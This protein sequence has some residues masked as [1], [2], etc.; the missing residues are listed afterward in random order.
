MVY[1]LLAG[2]E[3]KEWLPKEKPFVIMK[4]MPPGYPSLLR[5][6][7]TKNATPETMERALDHLKSRLTGADIEWWTSFIAKE[8]EKRET[9]ENVTENEY[10]EP[11]ESFDISALSFKSS[12][13]DQDIDEDEEVLRAE[14][15]IL[16]QLNKEH[17]PVR[18]T[19]FFIRMLFFSGPG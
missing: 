4:D 8:I 15:A 12:P 3:H 13:S 2:G 16:Q 14:A 6:E 18:Y 19:L 11:G 9:W 5:P 10:F 7:N 17:R 1:R